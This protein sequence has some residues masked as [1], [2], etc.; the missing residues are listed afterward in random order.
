M[1]PPTLH[2]LTSAEVTTAV[3]R[4]K[5]PFLA[6]ARQMQLDQHLEQ[7]LVD[8]Y[9]P[10][11]ATLQQ[12]ASRQ[13]ETLLVGVNGAQGAGK[14][15]LCRLLQVVLEQGFGLRAATL[16]IDDLYLTRSEREALAE[17]VHP[18]LKTRGVPGTHDVALGRQL[19][20]ELRQLQHGQQVAVPEFDKAS[21]DRR[22]SEAWRQVDGSLDLILFEGWC[23]GAVPEAEPALI[24]PVNRLECDED[25]ARTWRHFVN[26]S[27]QQDYAELF[28]ELDLLI[29]LKVPG[30]ANV[31]DWRGLQEQKLAASTDQDRP[32]KVM[33]TVTLQRFIMHYERL[34]RWMLAEMP[35]RAD[36]VLELNADHQI[37]AVRINTL[38]LT[39]DA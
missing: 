9:I 31:L 23:V 12:N 30:M 6:A 15:T 14:S 20:S 36:L 17:Q 7:V 3:N 35:G 13:D 28:A 16:S 11:A 4:C 2:N 33:D 34:T 38:T 29:M 22:P 1:L 39:G 24:E 25:P 10:L 5:A 21:D 27:L 19:L 26:Q 18:L 37:A 32:H 8:I